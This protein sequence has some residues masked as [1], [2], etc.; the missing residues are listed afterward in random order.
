LGKGSHGFVKLGRRD[1]KSYVLD[2]WN[3]L[4]K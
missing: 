1:G 4:S 2:C 3:R